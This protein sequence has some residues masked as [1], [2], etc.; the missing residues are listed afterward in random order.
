MMG[1]TQ[2]AKRFLSKDG[3]PVWVRLLRQ[4]DAAH[5][6]DLF[7]HMG[8]ESRYRRFH[9]P[10]DDVTPDQVW[11]EAKKIATAVPEEQ[12][13]LIAFSEL[14]GEGEVAVGAARIVWLSD[15]KAEIAMSVRDDRQGQG[16]GRRLLTMVLELARITGA[17]SVVG[18]VQNDNEPMWYLFDQLPYPMKR[19]VDGTESEIEIDLTSEKVGVET[20]V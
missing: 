2:L 17:E 15:N 7:E 5:L 11:D 20:A 9:Q 6:V 10:M 18:L 3:L 16:I 13:G 19:T 1:A 8:A 14:P 12:L 4:K